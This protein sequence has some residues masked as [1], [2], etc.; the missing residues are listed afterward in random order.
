MMIVPALL[1]IAV[2]VPF[3]YNPDWPGTA[4]L[5][6]LLTLVT[7]STSAIS[8][9][10]GIT[11]R[12]IGSLAAI[13]TGFNLPLTLL[14]GVLLPLSLAPDWLRLLAHLNPLYYA[15][16]GARALSEGR[17]RTW[18]VTLAFLVMTALTLVVFTLATRA[19]NKAIA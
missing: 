18:D 12:E 5:L 7:A 9:T 2:A 19:Y 3:D 8:C 14:S 13:V 4:M 16:E 1:L 11:L 17:I 10:L 15:V 6:G